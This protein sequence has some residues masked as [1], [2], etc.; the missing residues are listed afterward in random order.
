VEVPE[1]APV[2]PRPFHPRAYLAGRLAPTLVYP[3]GKLAGGKDKMN[4]SHQQYLERLVH[5]CCIIIAEEAGAVD[6]LDELEFA[7]LRLHNH[8]I[9]LKGRWDDLKDEPSK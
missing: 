4:K 5:A 6:D 1:R 3:R 2:T 8:L 7:Y 9:I